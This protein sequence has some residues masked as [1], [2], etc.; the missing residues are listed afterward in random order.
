MGEPSRAEDRP[1]ASRR[2]TGPGEGGDTGAARIA[3]SIESSEAGAGAGDSPPGESPP[4]DSH[5]LDGGGARKAARRERLDAANRCVAAE[6]ARVARKICDELRKARA[7]HRRREGGRRRSDRDHH[8]GAARALRAKGLVACAGCGQYYAMHGGGLRQHWAMGG[9]NDA[10]AAAAEGARS[11][12]MTDEEALVAAG[13]AN[14]PEL[15]INS[16]RRT[17]TA[18]ARVRADAPGN[19]RREPQLARER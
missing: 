4:G 11:P 14:G 1:R 7:R 13:R 16:R 8:R 9:I 12:Y 19:Q 10:C 18:C 6:I 5:G 2:G 15:G 17:W 3:G